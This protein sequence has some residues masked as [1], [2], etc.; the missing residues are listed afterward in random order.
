[1][2]RSKSISS[3]NQLE[4]KADIHPYRLAGIPMQEHTKLSDG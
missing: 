3:E 1:M 2:Y 4:L